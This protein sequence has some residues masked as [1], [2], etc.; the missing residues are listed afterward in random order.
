MM[1]LGG[2]QA[3]TLRANVYTEDSDVS[4]TGSRRRIR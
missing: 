3:L 2:A 4:Y 1:D